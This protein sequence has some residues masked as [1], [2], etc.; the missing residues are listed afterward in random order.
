MAQENINFG[1]YPND[2]NSDAIRTAFEKAQNNF[3]ELYGISTGFGVNSKIG[4]AHV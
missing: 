2:I 1:A 4:R 3:T